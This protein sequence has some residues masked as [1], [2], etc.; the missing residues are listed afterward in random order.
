M[1]LVDRG[2]DPLD[3]GL[4]AERTS[5]LLN[6]RHELGRVVPHVTRDWVDRE[7]AQ[8]AEGL[9]ENAVADGPEQVEVSQLGLAGLDPLEDLHHPACAFA[10]RRALAAGLVHVELR[11]P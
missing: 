5:P 9:A 3:R 2:E 8:G 11:R 1:A 7:V 6:V 10:A 4:A